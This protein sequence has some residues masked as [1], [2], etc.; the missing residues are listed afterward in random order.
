MTTRIVVGIVLI[1]FVAAAVTVVVRRMTDRSAAPVAS[2]AAPSQAAQPPETPRAQVTLDTRRQQMIGVRTVVV[3][4][5]TMT[6]ELRATGTV[7]YDETR[8]SDIN[9]RVDGWIR[10][11]YADYTGRPIRRGEP[12]FTLYS[13]DIIA[14]ENEYL[15]ALRGQSHAGHET[16]DT[17]RGYSDRLVAAARERLLRFDLTPEDI[18]QLQQS[19]HATDA[20]TFRSPASGVIV[21]KAAVRGMRVM[22]GQTLYRVADLSSVWVE[23]EVYE[24]EIAGLRTG[25]PASVTLQAYPGR[26]FSGRVSYIYPTVSEQTRTAR[27]RIALSNPSGVLKPNMLAT[28]SLQLP[29]SHALVLPADALVDTGTDHIVF[30]AEGEGRFAP[31]HVRIGRR[32]GADVEVI[33]G[34]EDGDQVAASATFFLDSESQLRGA[35][36]G[37]ETATTADT[38]AAPTRRPTVTFHTEPA[39]PKPGDATAIVTIATPDGAPMTDAD[40]QVVLFMAG[41]PTMNMP[42]M[43]TEARL[44]PASAGTYRGTV[45]VMTP[46]RWDVTVTVRRSG[47]LLTT[48]QFAVVAQ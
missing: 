5:T 38:A 31:R 44:L 12:L 9:T 43:R 17:A 23:A 35:L 2:A 21:E 8:Q 18:D 48:Q 26:S 30:V 13:P 14:T 27:V 15:L 47:Q 41:M 40:V 10:D 19:G 33:S 6:P 20:V 4:R 7:A 16:D 37:Y 46:G 32:S 34:L 22:A 39:I 25:L 28:V 36:Q 11:L 1:V 24:N 45:Q 3:H 29:Q 42:A